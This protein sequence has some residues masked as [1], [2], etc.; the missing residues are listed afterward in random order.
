MPREAKKSASE[1]ETPQRDSS[2]VASKQTALLLFGTIADTTWRMFVP[3]VGGALLGVWADNNFGTKPWF[4]VAGVTV[5]LAVV[6]G[7]VWLQI[8]ATRRD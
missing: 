5:G 6:V 7:L 1:H 3:S 4:T 2:E 8:K